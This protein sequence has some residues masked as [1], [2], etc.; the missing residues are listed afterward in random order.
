[1]EKED[2]VSRKVAKRLKDKGFSV[3]CLSQYTKLGTIWIAQEPENFNDSESC[4]SRPTLYDAQKWLRIKHNI[5]IVVEAN[6]SGW[7]YSLCKADN[8]TFIYASYESGPNEGGCWDSY[9]ECLN[10]AIFVALKRCPTSRKRVAYYGTNGCPGHHFTAITGFFSEQEQRDLEKLDGLVQMK[11]GREIMFK[12]FTYLK[13][14]ILAAN[15]SPDDKRGDSITVVAVENADNEKEVIDI[16]ND[17]PFLK[18]KFDRI[19]D[20]YNINY[21]NLI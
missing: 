10:D 21:N 13:Y 2:Y 19:C 1:M 3:P 4:C 18:D 7:Y 16:I 8:G 15:V 6:A 14:L 20:M 5:H 12:S 11:F 17:R 9:E